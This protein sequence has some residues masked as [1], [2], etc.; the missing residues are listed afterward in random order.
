MTDF[1]LRG[2]T[3]PQAKTNGPKLVLEGVGTVSAIDSR[4]QKKVLAVQRRAV[5]PPRREMAGLEVIM[6]PCGSST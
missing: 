1:E 5:R 2:P 4:A 6:R 3:D